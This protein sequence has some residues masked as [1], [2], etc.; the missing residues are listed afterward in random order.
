MS[1][2]EF[3]PANKGDIPEIVGVYR[4]LI[5][6]PGCTWDLDYPSE[7]TAEYDVKNEYLYIL[8]NENRIIAAASFGDFNELGDLAWKPKNPC[9]LMRIGVRRAYHK[10]GFGTI[11][12]RNIIAAAKGKGYDGIRMLVNKN[13]HAALAM[14][15]GNGFERCGEVYKFGSDYYCYQMEFQH[16]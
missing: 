12:L 13:N 6:A 11:M 4:G 2:Y 1:E 15:D 14:Y 8:K 9:E 16:P 10:K 3:R 5:G 7:E